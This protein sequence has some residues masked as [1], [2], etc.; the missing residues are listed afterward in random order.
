MV[1]TSPTVFTHLVPGTARTW[2]GNRDGRC[3]PWISATCAATDGPDEPGHDGKA[4]PMR[5]NQTAACCNG[6]CASFSCLTDGV[7]STSLCE[8]VPLICEIYVT[9]RSVS[10]TTH[11]GAETQRGTT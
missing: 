8:S 9:Q 10:L 3:M 6:V 2:S 7:Q 1:R 4:R 11:D 5:L